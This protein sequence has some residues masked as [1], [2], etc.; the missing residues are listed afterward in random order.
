MSN[1]SCATNH[2]CLCSAVVS[3]DE[4]SARR[5]LGTWIGFR[6]QVAV[7]GAHAQGHSAVDHFAETKFP[8]DA[9]ERSLCTSIAAEEQ[10]VYVANDHALEVGDRPRVTRKLDPKGCVAN[11]ASQENVRA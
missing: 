4:R 1:L 5:C 7:A 8:A 2:S 3:G 10:V 6:L 11:R 9:Q